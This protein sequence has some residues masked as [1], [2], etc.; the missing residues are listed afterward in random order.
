MYIYTYT[1]SECSCTWPAAK[2]D[3]PVDF[4]KVTQ[5]MQEGGVVRG[6]GEGGKVIT[7]IY[8]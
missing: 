8:R 7:C 3:R 2:G 6:G 5:L 4:P 1:K